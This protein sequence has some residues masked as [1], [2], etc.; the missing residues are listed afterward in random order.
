MLGAC[1]SSFTDTL[2]AVAWA[3]GEQGCLSPYWGA[4]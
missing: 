2:G 1:S 4:N 3:L